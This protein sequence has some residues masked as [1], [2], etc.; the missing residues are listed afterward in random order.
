MLDILGARLGYVWM[1]GAILSAAWTLLCLPELRNRGLEEIDE[2]FEADIPA[3]RFKNYQTS[4]L[5]GVVRA[6]EQ[7][8]GGAK[9]E[10]DV[11]LVE[12]L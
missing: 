4:G 5:A 8:N 6:L 1:G 12:E 9:G 10:V 3:W 7:G 2:L 11:E